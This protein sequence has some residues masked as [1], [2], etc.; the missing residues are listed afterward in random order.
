MALL[1]VLSKICE[2]CILDGIYNFV[3]E[4]IYPLQH[5]F[6]HGR[7]TVTQLLDVYN[8]VNTRLDSGSQ[9]DLIFLDFSKAFDSISHKL[10]IFKLRKFGISG[11]ILKWMSNYLLDRLQCVAVEGFESDLCHITSGVPQ[12]SLLGPF[13]FLLYINDLPKCIYDPIKVALFADDAKVY[14]DVVDDEDQL[15][16][17]IQLENVYKWSQIW[18][19]NFNAPKCY[20]LSISNK[21]KLIKPC[22]MLGSEILSEVC[23]FVDLGVKVDKKLSWSRHITDIKAKA[24]R[25]LNY[26]I[27]PCISRTHA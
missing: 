16:I 8:Y 26:G 18:K 21:K 27:Y 17:N 6:M 23:E 22:Y 15:N 3:K 14:G 12:G 9:I 1:P 24:I 7:S 5:G 13:L 25:N 2:K 11:K 20:V 10:L 19:M 4:H